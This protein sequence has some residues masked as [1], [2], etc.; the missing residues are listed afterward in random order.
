[1]ILYKEVYYKVKESSISLNRPIF[2]S[3]AFDHPYMELEQLNQLNIQ[4]RFL[5]QSPFYHQLKL[6]KVITI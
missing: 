2:V 4:S 3:V 6:C 5:Y 1:M